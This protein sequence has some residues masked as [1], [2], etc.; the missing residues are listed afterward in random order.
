MAFQKSYTYRWYIKQFEKAKKQAKA[1]QNS[2]SEQRLGT[3]PDTNTWSATECIAH[4]NTFGNIYFDNIRNGL[5]QAPPDAAGSSDSFKPR[6]FWRGVIRIFEPPYSVTFKTL[7]IF[8]PDISESADIDNAF[9]HFF[10]LQ[11]RFIDQ[12]QLSKQK[13][14]NLNHTKVS[15]PALTFVKMTLAECYAVAEAHQR[16]HLWQ[17]ERIITKLTSESTQ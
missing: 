10:D 1:L 15:N 2:A 3:K 5:D 17:A 14:F 11:D 9:R 7:S 4:L 12:L 16:R 8:E 6:L 13:G